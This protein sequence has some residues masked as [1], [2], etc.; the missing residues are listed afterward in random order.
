M[1]RHVLRAAL[2]VLLIIAAFG[3]RTASAHTLGQSYLFLE[4]LESGLSGWVE[5]T[6]VDLDRALGLETN[7]DGK[8]S[9]DEVNAQ[10][11]RVR[12]YVQQRLSLS[13]HG[14]SEAPIVFTDHEFRALP[15]GEYLM[16]R[17]R[18]NGLERAPPE[19]AVGYR[20]LFDADP[21]HKGFL[22]I[23]RNEITDYVNT[24]ESV[25]LV[26]SPSKMQ[27]GL[28]LNEINVWSAFSS[29]VIDGAW[30]ILIGLDH[31]L[32]LLALVLPA[33]LTR[34][35]RVWMPVDTLRAAM[36][37]LVKVVTLFTIAHSITLSVAAL[38]FIQLPSRLVESVIAAS[39]LVAAA[40]NIWPLLSARIGWIVFAFGL[41]HGIGFASVL[42]H[43]TSDRTQLVAKLIG[44]NLGVE[45]GQLAV[46]LIAFP[47]LF[48][49]RTRRYYRHALMPAASIAIGV[50]ALAWL[51][52]R[53]F[54]INAVPV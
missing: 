42:A 2:G 19:L 21:N 34:R 9:R 12:D 28:D 48:H 6:L 23:A 7:G 14:A 31:V 17:F 38:G 35:D 27:Q 1:R 51:I 29:F 50:L 32:F 44:F 54:D 24:G 5:V 25:A 40:N 16:L 4:F 39:V 33:A 45:L 46:V 26:F 47:L 49:L 10:I 37:Q 53:A 20:L 18:V 13:P 43:L 3:A 52:E 22:V 11:D 41:F 36:L 30:H 15:L 8:I